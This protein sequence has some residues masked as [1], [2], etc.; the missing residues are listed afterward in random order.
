VLGCCPSAEKIDLTRFWNWQDAPADTAPTINPVTLP[1]TTPSIAAGLTAPN[2]LGQLPGLINNVLQ[3]PTPN[4]SLL[5][6]LGQNFA[7]QHDF[8][9]TLANAAQLS[10]LLQNNSTAASQARADALK[11]SQ[12]LQQQAMGIIGGIV[13]G[14]GGAAAGGSGGKGG[15]SG[16]SGGSGSA[17]GS[18]GSNG[19]SAAS[20]AISAIAPILL[21]ALL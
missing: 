4:S 12:A 10:T 3:A 6:S 21:A 19:S 9:T 18:G 13:T 5:Q 2:S 14:Q 1:T 8:D 15:G 16:G 17:S 11:S 20:S 7:Q